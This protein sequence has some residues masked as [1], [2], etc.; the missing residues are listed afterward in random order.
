MGLLSGNVVG[1]RVVCLISEA[2][3]KIRLL[4]LSRTSYGILASER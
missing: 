3:L 1:L 2:F 4:K